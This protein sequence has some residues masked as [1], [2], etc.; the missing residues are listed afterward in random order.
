MRNGGKEHEMTRGAEKIPHR[1]VTERPAAA[2]GGSEVGNETKAEVRRTQDGGSRAEARD[3][4]PE[5]RSG[6]MGLKG[7]SEELHRQHPHEYHD[8]GPHHGTTTH[9]RHEPV[10]KVYGR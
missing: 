7:A 10:S 8:H 9:I 6:G 4:R 5:L 3:S 1:T 2:K